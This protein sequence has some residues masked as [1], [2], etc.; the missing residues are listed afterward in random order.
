MGV[1]PPPRAKALSSKPF[2]SALWIVHIIKSKSILLALFFFVFVQIE[3]KYLPTAPRKQ[4]T[5]SMT[6]QAITSM[7]RSLSTLLRLYRGPLLFLRA[8][9]SWPGT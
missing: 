2:L 5:K 1:P 6:T 9:V 3:M 4:R 7:L 8:F